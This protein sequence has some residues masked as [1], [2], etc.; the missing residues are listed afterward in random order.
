MTFTT[1]ELELIGCALRAYQYAMRDR[2]EFRRGVAAM[3][4]ADRL[5]APDHD[6]FMMQENRPDL[7][8][9]AR[10]MFAPTVGDLMAVRHAPD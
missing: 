10:E 9:Q 6:P 8:R 4:M 1:Q 7:V 5:Q 2:G 3:D